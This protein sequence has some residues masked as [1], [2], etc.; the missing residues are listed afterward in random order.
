[1]QYTDTLQADPQILSESAMPRYLDHPSCKIPRCN[2]ANILEP[3]LTG[4]KSLKID[5]NA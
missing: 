3:V 2:S 5:E 1:M 4:F